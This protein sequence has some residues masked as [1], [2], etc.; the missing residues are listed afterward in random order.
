MSVPHPQPILGGK[1]TEPPGLQDAKNLV[2]HALG[3]GH[4]LVDVGTGDE[5]ELPG[6]KRQLHGITDPVVNIVGCPVLPGPLDRP[7]VDV[8]T[9][10]A[11]RRTRRSVGSECRS[12]N[13][14]RASAFRVGSMP[15]WR[16]A[17]RIT[18]TV[19]RAFCRRPCSSNM[20][21]GWISEKSCWYSRPSPMIGAAP[22]TRQNLSRRTSAP[23]GQPTREMSSRQPPRT[24]PRGSSRRSLQPPTR[25]DA[26]GSPRPPSG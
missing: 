16:K 20:V 4:V 19:L 22:F 13:R 6:R 8:D 23:Y 10:H 12:S 24:L 5:I 21:F 11:C 3:V 9:H 14:C 18:A 26:A 7:V 15:A 17:S 25:S 2:Q 1:K